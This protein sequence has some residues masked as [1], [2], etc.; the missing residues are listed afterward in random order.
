MQLH[1]KSTKEKASAKN[2]RHKLFLWH[3]QTFRCIQIQC[4][5]FS[6]MR[7]ILDSIS[8]LNWCFCESDWFFLDFSAVKLKI[9]INWEFSTVN[10]IE[11]EIYVVVATRK[12]VLNRAMLLASL[13]KQQCLLL[14]A[15]IRNLLVDSLQLCQSHR[16]WNTVSGSYKPS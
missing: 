1:R 8:K 16:E 11:I 12:N 14:A 15:V 4:F 2:C 10:K 9:E 6:K 13:F 7:L 5:S 3:H